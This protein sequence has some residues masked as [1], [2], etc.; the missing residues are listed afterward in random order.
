MISFAKRSCQ[1]F[2][3]PASPTFLQRSQCIDRS[4]MARSSSHP[5]PSQ[6]RLVGTKPSR[7]SRQS[8]Q[9]SAF[10]GALVLGNII[11]IYQRIATASQAE[12]RRFDPDRPLQY[13]NGLNPYPRS[14]ECQKLRSSYEPS[15]SI[16]L[17]LRTCLR[18]LSHVGRLR[19]VRFSNLICDEIS[20]PHTD[21]IGWIVER[22]DRRISAPAFEAADIPSA[23]ARARSGLPLSQAACLPQTRRIFSDQLAPIHVLRA[24]N[25]AATFEV[26]PRRAAGTP[27]LKVRLWRSV[28][29]AP[30]LSSMWPPGND[31]EA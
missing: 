24:G 7:D 22:D 12:C 9:V 19:L 25:F 28:R 11:Y 4:R 5:L 27:A 2:L 15:D 16:A 17:G 8:G 29:N 30:R 21:G 20:G 31:A 13:F 18:R 26:A 1:H 6:S 14:P 10:L 23:E 3:R